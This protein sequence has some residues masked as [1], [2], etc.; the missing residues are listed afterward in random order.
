MFCIKNVPYNVE[1]RL[2]KT[3]CMALF[4]LDLWDFSSNDAQIFMC[5][6]RKAIRK[7]LALPKLCHNSL[8]NL[9]VDDALIDAQLYSRFNHF[10]KKIS[11]S[12]NEVVNLCSKLVDFDSGSTVSNNLLLIC[13]T[14]NANRHN[15]NQLTLLKQI[16]RKLHRYVTYSG[17][18]AYEHLLYVP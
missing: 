17:L 14:Y 6:W 2:F 16:C 1:Y 12:N 18:T 11:T 4:N 8:I 9:I 10:F 3:Y 13:C 15:Y 5:N 7:L